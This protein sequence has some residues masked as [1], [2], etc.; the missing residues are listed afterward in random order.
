MF[1]YTGC[2]QFRGHV[3]D[4]KCQPD[5]AA[6]FDDHW[7]DGTTLWPR[8]RLVGGKASIGSSVDYRNKQA[9]SYLHYLLLARPD[10]HVAQALLISEAGI[11]FLFGIGGKGI[12]SFDVPWD[13]KELYKLIYVFVFCVYEPGDYA[14]TTYVAMDREQDKNFVTYTMHIV[15]KEVDGVETEGIDCPG[16]IQVHASSPFETR[17]HVLLNPQ[18][19]LTIRGKRL[20]AQRPIVPFW[21]SIQRA[22]YP[23]PYSRTR[24]CTWRRGNGL[25][26]SVHD[27]VLVNFREMR[28]TGLRQ[29]GRPF[30]TLSTLQQVL[31][32][33]YDILES[34]VKVYRSHP[35][36]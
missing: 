30:S 10:L 9:T 7:E 28:R 18:S 29:P 36:H 12:R 5:Y 24:E 13:S 8:I 26:E 3:T 31:E 14:E 20:T 15:T 21:N 17:T 19:K 23:C 34:T 25:S 1:K 22:R 32:T 27:S 4:T 11:R 6:A 35:M 16:F 2:K 33:S